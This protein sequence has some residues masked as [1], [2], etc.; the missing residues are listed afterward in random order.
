MNKYLNKPFP[1]IEQTNHKIIASLLFSAF[2]Y[3][4]LIVFQPFNISNIQYYKPI[5]IL[6]FFAITF[7]V[8]LFSLLLIPYFFGKYFNP[9]NWTIKKNLVFTSLIILIITVL[10]W[11]YNSTVGENITTQFSLLYF[12]FITVSVGAFPVVL[13]NFLV[14]KYLNKRNQNI[15]D[16]FNTNI[17]EQNRSNNSKIITII[18]ENNNESIKIDLDQL[19]CIKSEGNYVNI[20]YKINGGIER[21]LIRNSISKILEQLMIFKQINRCHRSFVVN[22]DNVESISGNARNFNLQIK[23]LDFPIPVS[24]SFPK[25]LISQIK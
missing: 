20:F 17:D 19:L 4:F 14:E 2:V 8:L 5:F 13:L 1:F 21:K 11:L 6:G 25:H 18:S 7:F 23:N 24:R 16:S 3:V 9:D 15:A 12:I 10:N 22:F